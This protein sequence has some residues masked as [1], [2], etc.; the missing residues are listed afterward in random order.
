MEKISRR[1]ALKWLGLGA[2]T[3]AFSPY[4]RAEVPA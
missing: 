4:V 1:N 2:A 3:L